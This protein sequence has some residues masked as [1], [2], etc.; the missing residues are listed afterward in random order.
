[1]SEASRT[2]NCSIV[3]LVNFKEAK[4]VR[5]QKE[6]EI[7]NLHTRINT[8]KAEEEKAMKQINETRTK[9]E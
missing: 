9:A 1:M 8:L 5:E 2:H 7:K 3:G 6:L 4:K